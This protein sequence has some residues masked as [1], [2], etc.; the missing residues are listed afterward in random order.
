MAN[1][2]RTTI[3]IY[4]AATFVPL[5]N[6]IDSLQLPFVTSTEIVN[7]DEFLYINFETGAKWYFSRHAEDWN[8]YIKFNQTIL[9]LTYTSGWIH[10]HNVEGKPSTVTLCSSPS[11]FYISI[12]SRSD[13]EI[14]RGLYLG[15]EPNL[16]VS[17]VIKNTALKSMTLNNSQTYANCE[18]P[19]ILNYSAG[20]NNIQYMNHAN[21]VSNGTKYFET[22]DLFACSTVASDSV[23]TFGGDNYYSVDTNCLIPMDKE[24]N[25]G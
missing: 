11:M 25:N 18:V 5:K 14:L 8:R 1:V 22:N 3:P 9:G 13:S 21:I 20:V 24:Q 2:K 7:G 6:A 17:G 4:P 16:S 23:I 10:T 19:A 15:I 12:R